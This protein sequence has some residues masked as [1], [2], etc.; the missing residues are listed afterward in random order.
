MSFRLALPVILALGTPL[1]ALDLGAMTPEEEAA[2]G[3]AVRAYLLDNPRVLIEVI[4]LLESQEAAATAA[5][6]RQLAAANRDALVNDGHSYVGGNPDGD[7]TIVEFMDYRCGYCRR[8][9]DEVNALLAQDGNIRFIVKEYPI[10]GDQSLAAAQFAVAVQQ[11]HGDAVYRDVHDALML[12]ESD[13][14]SVVLGQLADAYGLDPAPILA[15]METPAVMDVLTANQTLGQAMQITGTPTFVI[16]D[17]M[18]R[19][20]VPL[21][22]MIALVNDERAAAAAV[23]D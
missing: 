5:M 15:A 18:V 20:Y 7:I 10:L 17:Q 21:D 23:A 6:D 13:V 11:I 22:Q 4:N 9:F 1:A 2:F 12:L 19:G 16:G 8:A 14:S 3:E